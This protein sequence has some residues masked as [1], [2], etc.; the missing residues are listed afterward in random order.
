MS[1]LYQISDEYRAAL[2]QVADL[3][4]PPEV[5]AD[6]VEGLQGA[7]TDKLAAVIAYSLEL[8]ILATG[9]ADAAKRMQERAKALNSRVDGL[10]AYALRTMQ[11]TGIGGVE[12]DEF[13]AKPAK[14]PPSVNITDRDAIPPAYLRQP[15]PPA[16]EPDKKAIAEALKTGALVPGA[17]LVHGWRLAVR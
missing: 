16:P 13:A 6:T 14:R 5:V 12:T 4:L 10:R 9:A 7:V 1:T 8:D 15:E 3:D 2:A 11:L 17:E